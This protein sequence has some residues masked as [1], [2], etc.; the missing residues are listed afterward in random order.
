MEDKSPPKTWVEFAER[1][2]FGIAATIIIC[3]FF[4]SAGFGGR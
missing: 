4:L 3:V 2:A 1:H